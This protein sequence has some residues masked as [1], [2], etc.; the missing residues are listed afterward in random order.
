MRKPEPPPNV[1]VRHHGA[2]DGVLWAVA[3]ILAGLVV[4]IV[5]LGC[6]DG[7]SLRQQGFCDEPVAECE[8]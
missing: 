2:L 3:L 8:S 4:G 6:G 1:I 5:L 7:C